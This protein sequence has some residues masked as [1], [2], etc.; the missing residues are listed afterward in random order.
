MSR[1]TRRKL[2]IAFWAFYMLTAAVL[3]SGLIANA[4]LAAIL[5]S[6]LVITAG[7][8]GLLEEVTARGNRKA[9]RRIDESI[10]QVSDWVQRSYFFSKE[11]K[12]R[13]DLR[14]HN[15]DTK[16]SQL[17]QVVQK[18]NR[19]LKKR[20]IETEN[21]L[22][23]LK[24]SIAAERPKPLTVFERRI[25]R[26]VKLAR[27]EG[28]VTTAMYSRSIRVSRTVAWSDLKKLSGMRIVRKRGK[29]RNAYYILA[30]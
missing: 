19:E 23:S 16:R 15:I 6:L 28:M 27:R 8:Q 29:G 26:A 24:R 2:N 25:G 1:I 11:I 9:I 5:L 7:F 12:E 20:L 14:F 10:Q 22:N 30:V 4:I 3:I 13:F 21:K 17:E 18:N